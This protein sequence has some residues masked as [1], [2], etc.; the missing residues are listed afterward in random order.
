MTHKFIV[1]AAFGLFLFSSCEKSGEENSV[2]IGANAPFSLVYVQGSSWTDYA[3]RAELHQ[4]GLLNLEVKG[5]LNNDHRKSEYQ[6]SY[7]T[8]TLVKERLLAATKIDFKSSYGFSINSPYDLP[9]TIINYRIGIHADSA[10]IYY[11]TE[12]ELPE[13]LESL[14]FLIEEII[15]NK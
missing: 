2:E 11:P 5:G 13:E 15:Y 12:K 10:A 7:D 3:Y 9:V 14:K 4:N 1:L 6:I 8:V